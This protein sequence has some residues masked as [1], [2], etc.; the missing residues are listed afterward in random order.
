MESTTDTTVLILIWLAAL[1]LNVLIG[2]WAGKVGR[3]NGRSF[4]LCFCL[5]FFLG[6][7]GVLIVY[8][9]G[10]AYDSRPA[11]YGV[12]PP[13]DQC[14][15]PDPYQQR[16]MVCGQ[17]GKL[18]ERSARFCPYCGARVAGPAPRGQ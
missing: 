11:P 7:I 17:C 16:T 10:P 14:P 15:P 2:Y 8:V 1:A 12:A 6:L 9:I 18:V 4:G 13:P 5:G 3:R